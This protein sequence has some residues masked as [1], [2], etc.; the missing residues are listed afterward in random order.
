MA[1]SYVLLAAALCVLVPLAQWARA[2]WHNRVFARTHG[3]QP[4]PMDRLLT[5]LD[6]LGVGI[7]FEL[8]RRLAS[9]SLLDYMRTRFEDNGYTFKS[10]VLLDDFYWTCE[11]RNIQALLA[12]QFHSFGVGIDREFERRAFESAQ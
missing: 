7:L 4:A 12:T 2:W 11:P 3:C 5:W 8:E 6:P 1:N 9:H 10:R